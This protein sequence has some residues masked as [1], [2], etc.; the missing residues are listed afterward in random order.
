[1]MRDCMNH[2]ILS[3]NFPVK[4]ILIIM[5]SLFL[6]TILLGKRRFRTYIEAVEVSKEHKGSS[7]E[8]FFV[9]RIPEIVR[10]LLGVKPNDCVDRS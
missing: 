5:A 9:I 10:S 8:L 6:L 7:F 2:F 3:Y 1:M 4:L